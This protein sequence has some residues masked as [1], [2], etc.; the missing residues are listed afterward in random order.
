MTHPKL[1]RIERSERC[2]PVDELVEKA[3]AGVE[4]IQI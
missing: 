4:I 2:L 3:L 1:E